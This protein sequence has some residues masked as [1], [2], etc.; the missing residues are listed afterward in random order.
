MTTRSLRV[1]PPLALLLLTLLGAPVATAASGAYVALGDSYSSGLG[2][3]TYIASSGACKRSRQ[4]Y[5]FQLGRTLSSFRACAAA[6]TSDILDHQLK[7][8]P[9][10]TK[11][12]TVTIGGNDAGFADVVSSCLF[13]SASV[14]ATRVDSASKFIRATLPGRLRHA[15]LAIRKHAPKATVVVAGYPR[16]LAG[17]PCSAAG[18]IDVASQRLLNTAS[19][20][21]AKTIGTEVRRH[22]RFRFADVRAAFDGHGVCS[23]SP[24]INGLDGSIASVFHPNPAGYKAYARAIKVTLG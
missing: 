20:L 17:R 21:L 1:A 6:T 4:S 24:W 5:V 3:T 9:K 14:C 13:G 19:D 7:P 11:L 12:V 10:D 2:S 8:F 22:L 23:S 18:K 16:L 15:Y